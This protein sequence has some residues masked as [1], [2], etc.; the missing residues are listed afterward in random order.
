MPLFPHRIL[1]PFVLRSGDQVGIAVRGMRLLSALILLALAAF[2]ASAQT[3]QPANRITQRVDTSRVQALGNH[4]PQWANQANSTG[5]LP[6]DQALEDMTL[7]L[8]RSPEQETAFK[9]LLADQQNPASPSFHHWL[10]PAEV[11]V[12]FGLSDQD[13]ATITG[14]LQSQG[15]HVNWISPSRIFIGF[16][17][18]AADM[19]RAFQTEMH[20]YKVNGVERMSVSTEPVIPSALAPAI[21][22]VRGL[23]TINE[24]PMHQTAVV[25]SASPLVTTTT[26]AHYIGPNDFDTIYNVPAAYTGAGMTI[27]IVGWAHVSTTDLDNFRAK[28]LASFAN[29]TQVVPTAYHGVDPGPALTSPPSSSSNYLGSQEEATLDVIRAGSVAPGANLLLVVSSPTTISNDGIGADAQYLVNLTPVPQVM[30]ISFGACESEVAQSDV[31]FWDGLFSQGALEGMSVFVSSGDSAAAGCDAAFSAPPAATS[32]IVNSPNYICTSSYATCVGGTQFAD[33]ASPSS[34]WSSSN[35][36]GYLSALGYIPEGGWNESWDG[37]NATVAGTGG[38]VSLFNIPTPAWQTGT[39]V[40]A[41]RAGRYTPDVSFSTANHD[42]YFACMAAISGGGCSGSPFGFIVFSGTSASAPGMAGV[43]ALLDQKLGGGQGN[44]NPQLYAMAASAP[45]AFHDVTVAT[46]G[47]SPCDINTPSLCNNSIPGP[48]GLTGGQ[49]GFLVTAGYDEVTGLGSLNVTNFINN[50]SAAKTTPTVTVTPN[51]TSIAVNQALSVTVAVSGTPTPTGSVTL[52]SGTYT[53]ASTVLASGSATISVPAWSLAA[54]TPTLSASYMPDASSSSAYNAASGT[55]TVNVS[56][57]TPTVSVTPGSSNITRAQSLSVTVA[58]SSSLAGSPTPTGSV[59]LA[60]GGFTSATFLLI[61]GGTTITIPPALLAVG[62]DTLT[63]TYTPD[64]SGS[65]TYSNASGLSSVTVTKATPTVTVTPTPASIAITQPLSVTVAVSSSVVGSPTA[66]GTVTLSSG[67]YT[68]AATALVG[69]SATVSVPAGSLASGTPTLTAS[70]S[71]DINYIANTG[72]NTVTVSK[73]TPTVTVTPSPA[74]ITTVQSLSVTVSVSGGG[75]NPTATGTVTL[76]GGGYTSAATTLA[77]GSATVV[78]PAGSL[79]VATDTLTASYTPDAPG[80][81]TYNTASGSNIVAVTKATPTVT[82][83]P[84]SASVT[85]VQSLSV[86]IGVSGGAGNP[87]ATGTVTLSSGTYSSGATALVSGSATITIGAGTL[88]V[89]SDTLTATFTPGAGSTGTYN[90]ATGT[91]GVTVSKITPTVTVSP[92]AASIT[93]LQSTQVTVTV[94]GGAGNP[95]VTGSVVLAG[96]GYISVSTALSGGSALITVPVGGLMAGS[97]TLTA[98]FTPDAGASAN[99]LGATGTDS[100]TVTLVTPTVTMSASPASITTTQATTVSVTVSGGAGNPIPSGAVILTSGS[101]SSSA[102][103]LVGGIATITVP[104]GALPVGSDSVTGSY[105]PTGGGFYG[106]ATGST[107]VVVT[108]ALIPSF[109]F[110]GS[111]VTVTKGSSNTATITLTPTNGFAGSVT[112]TAA[113][114]S[115]PTGA[116]YPPTFSFGTT[117]PVNM[118]AGTAAT[119][120]LTVSTTPASTASLAYPRTNGSPWYT[121]GG[122]ILACLLLFGIPAKR[123]KLRNLL[124]MFMLFAVLAGGMIACG[125][126]SSSGGG[127]GTT[128]AGTTTGTYT[129]TITGTSGSTVSTSSPITLTIQ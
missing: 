55:N 93:T 81:S 91:A 50:Y 51:P 32:A 79:A 95:T 31:D 46:S 58:V 29:P 21:K 75:G 86:T 104:A 43:A 128:I 124:G 112:L 15:L 122:A 103:A 25:E 100:V 119:A 5:L 67:T 82:V 111:T 37:S 114:V 84:T 34:Y 62:T 127:G 123:R 73:A 20:S 39:G 14:W 80:A 1:P 121:G 36:T 3:A 26:G 109:T 10:T 96:G 28:T 129:F 40:P 87:A 85:T 90:S 76:S 117:S 12:R 118:S 99:Y 107:T 54:G 24:R 125:G 70:Y 18:T 2:A 64:A 33:T 17:G 48:T 94:N 45:S 126:G 53:S 47:V 66:T 6:A 9:Q 78:V 65:L 59:T 72:T 49:P 69:G 92:S 30:T 63:A 60:G 71:S 8:T 101:Y 89:G 108:Q 61:S 11:G 41:A 102:T 77:S 110:T 98:T 105:V 56:M 106:A 88:A 42:G 97:D 120:T 23:Y 52:S 38:G 57:V 19:G 35:S 74:S 115:S 113:L 83:T 27:G 7:V 22:A 16:G 13:I 116:Q 4:H 68:S 44:L